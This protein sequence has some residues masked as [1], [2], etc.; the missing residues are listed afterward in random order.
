MRAM[1]LAAGLGTRMRPMTNDLPKAL[2]KVND[3]CLIEYGMALL[4]NAGITEI[5]INTHYQAN[6]LKQY[7]KDGRDFG[8]QLH[9]FDEPLLLDTGGGIFNALSFLKPE[10]FVVLSCDIITDFDVANLCLRRDDDLAHLVMVPNPAF[11]KEGD[12][13]I[14][15]GRLTLDAKETFTFANIGLYNP[16]LFQDCS[17]E[18][19]PLKNL[20]LKGIQSQRITAECHQGVWHNIGTPQDLHLLS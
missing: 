3:K 19:F 2:V 14:E 8:V 20:F 9:Y 13:G 6:K 17:R 15:N 5:A 11:K 12:F 16:E 1:I 10:P 4:K 7:L 18:P